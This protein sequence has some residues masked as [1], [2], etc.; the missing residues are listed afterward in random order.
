MAV[1]TASFLRTGMLILVAGLVGS[2]LEGK[3]DQKDTGAFF[4]KS[5]ESHLVVSFWAS[6]V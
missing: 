3:S 4:E 1:G 6:G 5:T 2:F